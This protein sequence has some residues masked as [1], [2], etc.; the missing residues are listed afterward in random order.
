MKKK[1]DDIIDEQMMTPEEA[2][3]RKEDIKNFLAALKAKKDQGKTMSSEDLEKQDCI[4]VTCAFIYGLMAVA[5]HGF[6]ITEDG[7]AVL[8]ELLEADK[9]EKYTPA[10]FI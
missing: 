5:L 6:R 10:S 9:K 1:F 3:I 2:A 7:E 4:T 8:S